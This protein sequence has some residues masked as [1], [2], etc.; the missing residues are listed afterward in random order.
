MI[1]VDE[2]IHPEFTDF[3][4]CRGE[5]NYL[6]IKSLKIPEQVNTQHISA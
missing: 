2:Q 6:S 3:L 4:W 5:Q 1:P